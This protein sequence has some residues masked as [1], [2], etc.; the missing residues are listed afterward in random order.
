MYATRKYG[1]YRS[2]GTSYRRPYIIRTGYKSGPV[3][4]GKK[5]TVKK[6]RGLVRR[7]QRFVLR[8]NPDGS[9]NKIPKRGYIGIQVTSTGMPTKT[10]FYPLSKMSNAAKYVTS[11]AAIPGTQYRVISAVNDE[12]NQGLLEA[13]IST[14]QQTAMQS[15]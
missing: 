11:K 4:F 3:R 13:M 9:Y 10:L 12:A 8:P 15:T 7:T 2:Y 1:S 6:C 5:A 14:M